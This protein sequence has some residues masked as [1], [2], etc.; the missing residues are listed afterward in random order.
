MR[1]WTLLSTSLLLTAVVA[2]GAE[3][4]AAPYTIAPDEEGVCPAADDLLVN[5]RAQLQAGAFDPLRPYLEK[6]LVEERGLATTLSLLSTILP[7]LDADTVKTLVGALTADDTG[8]TLTTVLPH[9]QNI[10]EYLQGSSPFVPGPHLA[11]VAAAHDIVVN[12]RTVDNVGVIRDL[13]A[14]EVVRAEN[15]PQGWTLAAPGEGEQSWLGAFVHALDAANRI[16]TLQTLLEKIKI[17]QDGEVPEEG[18][19]NIV[20][21]R[22]AFVVLSRL[23]ASNIS[24]PDFQL[25]P[26][27]KLLDDLLVPV[28]DGDAEA[29][30][31]LDALLDLLGLLVTE[32]SN[33]FE[34]TQ[35]FMGCVDR[36]DTDAAIPGMLFDYL[37]IDELSAADLLNDLAKSIDS[38]NTGTLRLALVK[39]LGIA[40]GHSD[41]LSDNAAV[42]G[43]LID[44]TVAPTLL[45]VIVSLEDTGFT[46]DIA[47]FFGV[48]LTCKQPPATTPTP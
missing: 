8:T 18:E 2:C 17:S 15:L 35:A 11:P 41:Q 44:P 37:T 20:V 42:L 26:V 16:P 38:E 10:I 27:R 13:L 21:G 23:L 31:A 43:K 25:A 40:L 48:I 6:I 22:A 1:T 9:L 46:D 14:L 3:G 29:T 5:A 12:C 34:S 45:D 7:E 33:T 32:Q 30:A 36:H 39:V 28:L 47:E 19:Q 4:T 24:A